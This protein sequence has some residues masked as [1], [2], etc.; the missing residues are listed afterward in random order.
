M[1]A[2]QPASFL[3][4]SFCCTEISDRL[5]S[6]GAVQELAQGVDGLVDP[7]H[8]VV[9]VAEVRPALGVDQR[10]V[11][12]GEPVADV[13]Q[14]RH[15]ALQAEQVALQVVDAFGRLA[16]VVA[17]EDVL[18]ELLELLLELVDD[19]EIACRRRSP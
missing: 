16:A 2:A 1:M 5:A 7:D 11:E 3:V 12:A 9:D 18:L 4:T 6:S 19:R 15:R 14:R 17:A 8:V 10:R 13:D